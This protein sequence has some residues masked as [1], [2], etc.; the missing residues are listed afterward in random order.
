MTVTVS[1]VSTRVRVE[2][3][4]EKEV[5]QQL[6][7]ANEA[8]ARTQDELRRAAD[9]ERQ[10]ETRLVDI[11]GQVSRLQKDLYDF[12]QRSAPLWQK[13]MKDRS[14]K[15]SSSSLVAHDV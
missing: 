7:Q 12:K 5:T 13:E 15:I 1:T 3:E 6:K 4:Q 14:S 9:K 8:V 11:K 2:T 10:L